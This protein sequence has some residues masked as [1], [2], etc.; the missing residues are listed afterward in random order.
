[1]GGIFARKRP[2]FDSRWRGFI[3]FRSRNTSNNSEVF[4]YQFEKATV[5]E[6][7]IC[8]GEAA[9]D[10]LQLASEGGA[11]GMRSEPARLLLFYRSCRSACA[12]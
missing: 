1:M 2:D 3:F 10:E 8:S 6:R 5:Y 7:K 12:Y 11:A 4:L 9:R